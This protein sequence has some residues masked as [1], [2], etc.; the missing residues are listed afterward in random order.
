MDQEILIRRIKRIGGVAIVA[1]FGLILFFGSYYVVDPTERAGVRMMGTV[2]TSQ[3]I[4]PGLH[5]KVPVIS[6]VDKVQ[7]SLTTVHIPAFE[8]NTV[9][10]QRVALDI[11]VSYEVPDDAVFHL[12]YQVGRSDD[13]NIAASIQPIVRD[14]VSRVFASKNT[15]FISAQREEIQNEVTKV[16]HEAINDLFKVNIR[17]LQIASITFS[18]AFKAS[19][20]QAVLAKN[21]AVQ[22]ENNKKV[23]EYQAQQRVIAAEGQAR[24]AIAAADGANKSAILQAE[25]K[26]RSV[27][28]AA[29]ADA[30][31][32]KLQSEAEAAATIVQAQAQ[33]QA[34]ELAGQGNASALA[35][36][37]Q[38]AGGADKFIAKIEAE[39]KMKWNGSVPQFVTGGQGAATQM[40]VIFPMNV[41]AA[42]PQAQ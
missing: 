14:R 10:N 8:V 15:N 9:D 20:D 33:K 25:A 41:P 27:E 17:S 39:A 37:I 19:N 1:I 38:A 7:V 5:F 31:A 30:K 35:A 36:M 22:E 6:T 3:P 2:T 26:A 32:R 12:L 40:P 42:K 29:Q 34:L 13:S 16:V 24:E 4:G 28:L 18:D 11:N 23:V 21:K